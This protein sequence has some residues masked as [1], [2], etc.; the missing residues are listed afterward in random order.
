VDPSVSA[1]EAR[2]ACKKILASAQFTHAP[3]M[4]R[5]LQF[6]VENAIVGDTRNTSEYAIGIA[7]F[8]RDASTYYTTEDPSVRVQVGRL[9]EKLKNYYASVACAIQIF[10][11]L[12]SYMPTFER[13]IKA[14][15]ASGHTLVFH[16]I[17]CISENCNGEAFTQGLQEE[18]LHQL[19]KSF[20]GVDIVHQ[21]HGTADEKHSSN[22]RPA[23]VV[24]T[25]YL[26]DACTRIDSKLAR[27]SVR[28]L[29]AK[30]RRVKWSEQF[31]SKNYHDIT[32]QEEL[33]YSICKALKQFIC[34]TL[35]DE[36]VPPSEVT[37]DSSG[38]SHIVH[39]GQKR[40]ALSPVALDFYRPEENC[41]DKCKFL[42]TGTRSI[43]NRER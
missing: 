19:F 11:P 15:P 14:E 10:I 37:I 31:D 20:D 25:E 41:T 8:D 9:R 22:L 18:L 21:F 24:G 30:H 13:V 32:L 28:L 43:S 4:S 1:E 12:G 40:Q 3:R 42:E 34:N 6:L 7:V 5:L 16:R 26:L 39:I 36:S 35:G 17:K 27:T 29:D 23:F 2:A 38:E 33:A